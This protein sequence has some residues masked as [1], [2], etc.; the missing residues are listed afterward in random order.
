MQNNSP[1]MLNGHQKMR[2]EQI[3]ITYAKQLS[4]QSNVEQRL[5]IS[6]TQLD[7]QHPQTMKE[8]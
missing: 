4:M 7:M 2:Q 6:P 8:L 3:Q 1:K 5:L